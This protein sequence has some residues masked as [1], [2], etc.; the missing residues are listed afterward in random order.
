[1]KLF[2]AILPGNPRF[3]EIEFSLLLGWALLFPAKRSYLYFLGFIFILGF[4]VLRKLSSL[5][6]IALSRFTYFLLALNGLFIFSA[7][8][9]RHPFK[10]ALFASDVFLS[11]LWFVFFY[12]EKSDMDRYLRLAA[13]WI[14]VSSCAMIVFFALQGGR[15]PVTPIFKNPILQGIASALAALVFLYARLRKYD[16]LDLLLLALNAGAVVISASKAAFLGLTVFA[17]AMILARKKKWLFY[18]I[19]I[20]VL[21]VVLPNPMRRMVEH[22]LRHDPYVLNRL[23]IWHMS[24]R[25]FRG[26]FWTGV[27]PDLF[28]AAAKKYN[29]P[30]EKGPARYFK[31][32]ESAHSDYWKVIAENGLPGLIFI[33]V[34]LFF[35]IRRLLSPPWFPLPKLLLAF[36]LAQMLLLNFIFNFFF[37]LLFLLL[38]QDFLFERRRFASLQPGFRGW[39]ACL[40]VFAALILYLFPFLS[41]RCLDAAAREKDFIRRFSLLKR[42]ALFSPLDPGPPLAKSRML[43][44]FASSHASLEAWTDGVHNLRLARKLDGYDT[45]PLLLESALFADLAADPRRYPA[46]G[47]EILAPLRRA[48]AL[49][50]FNPFLKL[51]AAEVLR[52][53]GRSPEARRRAQAALDLEPDYAAAILFIHDLDGRPAADPA[54][55]ARI[56]GIRAKAAGLRASPG[57]YLYQLHRLPAPAAAGN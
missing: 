51:Q 27:G 22:S 54:L 30:Q 5:K 2:K 10:S 21:L 31:L 19:A 47:E 18:F 38:A 25:M 24:A 4:V 43:R 49:D 17:A 46:R 40:L 34:C 7:F 12:V 26:H 52:K 50:P 11:S 13:F 32:P 39:V 53:F 29:F 20:M 14:S 57:S 6:N 41:D 45:S 15:I 42:A 16:R 55:Q 9:S 35:A 3:Q 36:L 8:F 44:A 56:A 1:M 28:A 37:L 33:L 23:D 48:E